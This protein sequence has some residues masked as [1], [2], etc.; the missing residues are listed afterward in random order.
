MTDKPQHVATVRLNSGLAGDAKIAAEV[1][2]I[3]F[4]ELI[5]RGLA[6][7]LKALSSDEQFR[8][9]LRS[10]IDK[11]QQLLDRLAAT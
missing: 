9:R 1:L 8:V 11:H 7:E 2:G 3:S 10:N 4:N 5:A 6:R